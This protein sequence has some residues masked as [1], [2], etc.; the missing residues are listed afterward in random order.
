MPF[1][2]W[3]LLLR[4]RW[5]MSGTFLEELEIK[6]TEKPALI[7]LCRNGTQFAFCV[8]IQDSKG[9]RDVDGLIPRV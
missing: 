5:E 2:H 7:A 3:P 1:T 8:L 4:A 6:L 9:L